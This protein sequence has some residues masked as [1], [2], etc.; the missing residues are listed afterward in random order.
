MNTWKDYR[1]HIFN[2]WGIKTI[3]N[4]KE[5]KELN[6]TYNLL[7]CTGCSAQKKDDGG[8]YKPSQLY[9]GAKN[10]NFYKTMIS[11]KYQFGTLSDLHGLCL[12]DE[13]Y[14]TYDIHPSKLIDEDFKKL[15]ERI[16]EKL[17]NKGYDAVLYYNP[18]PIM[19]SPY[20]KMLSHLEELPVY[21]FTKL[22]IVIK[23]NRLF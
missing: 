3:N 23:K 12:E 20:F 4:N 14:T 6:S 5:F 15:G 2:I 16:E 9:L 8:Y 22:D 1:N 19:G 21:Y 7:I 17:N 11:N 10:V 18:S 13:L